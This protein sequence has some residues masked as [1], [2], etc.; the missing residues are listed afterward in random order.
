MLQ[1]AFVMMIPTATRI[2]VPSLMSRRW[3]L[4][5]H[6]CVVSNAGFGRCEAPAVCSFF[7]AA[8]Y[9][10]AAAVAS[11]LMANVSY[12]RYFTAPAGLPPDVL[13]GSWYC[14][15]CVKENDSAAVDAHAAAEAA[16]KAARVASKKGK[17]KGQAV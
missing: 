16:A 15:A 10:R 3:R 13:N 17:A 7:Y 1:K 14:G 12:A 5:A 9:T 8:A 2:R 4:P 6:M 11:T